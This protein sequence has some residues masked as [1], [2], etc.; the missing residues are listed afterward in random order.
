M[1]EALISICR[2][3]PDEQLKKDYPSLHKAISNSWNAIYKA[4]G[5]PFTHEV[6]SHRGVNVIFS[7]ISDLGGVVVGLMPPEFAAFGLKKR[8]RKK[9][10]VYWR[11]LFC[12]AAREMR[13][14]LVEIGDYLGRDHATAINSCNRFRD[15]LE[16]GDLAA[17]RDYD[18]VLEAVKDVLLRGE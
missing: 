13:F 6:S 9:E 2:N 4:K 7:R 14:T 1:L 10:Y 15:L 5:E 18:R 16:N 17:R 11:H 8:W 12:Y 3:A